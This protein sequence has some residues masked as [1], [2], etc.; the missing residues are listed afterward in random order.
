MYIYTLKNF[1][2]FKSN[3]ISL[4]VAKVVWYSNSMMVFHLR[5]AHADLYV[6]RSVKGQVKPQG[7]WGG[8]GQSPIRWPRTRQ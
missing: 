2:I 1:N 5:A 3:L 6:K 4:K 8:G 7:G